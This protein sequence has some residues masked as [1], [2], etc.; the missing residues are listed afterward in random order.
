MRK[1]K[2]QAQTAVLQGS[3]RQRGRFR[4]T[5]SPEQSQT[6]ISQAIRLNDML[7]QPTG[8]DTAA[9]CPPSG[10]P[11]EVTEPYTGA[12]NCF[13]QSFALACAFGTLVFHTSAMSLAKGSSGLGIDISAWMDKST[14]RICRAGLHLSFRMSKQMRPSL[15][16]LG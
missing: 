15:S 14:C 2:N 1:R 9:V 7:M 12:A 5:T 6:V 11:E 3:R 8:R 10:I 13:V 4:P 16:M